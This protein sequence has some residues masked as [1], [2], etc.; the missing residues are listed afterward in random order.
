ML[1]PST[2]PITHRCSTPRDTL[3][4]QRRSV[5]SSEELVF[6]AMVWA[7]VEGAG[8]VLLAVAGVAFFVWSRR[9]ARPSRPA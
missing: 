5:E 4:Y 9:R 1:P 6:D 8:T 3:K 2:L 7:V